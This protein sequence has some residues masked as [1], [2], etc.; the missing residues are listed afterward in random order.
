MWVRLGSCVCTQLA[1]YSLLLLGSA[2]FLRWC[3]EEVAQ[4][5]GRILICLIWVTVNSIW[6]GCLSFFHYQEIHWPGILWTK[7]NI[8]HSLYNL[9]TRLLLLHHLTQWVPNCQ[10]LLGLTGNQKMTAAHRWAIPLSRSFQTF[11]FLQGL[12]NDNHLCSVIRAEVSTWLVLCVQPGIFYYSTIISI[13]LGH[14]Y[15]H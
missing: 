15:R 7:I 9:C 11:F 12:L 1:Q 10:W 4:L 13:S 14:L 8:P 2:I 6:Q 3:L 5:C